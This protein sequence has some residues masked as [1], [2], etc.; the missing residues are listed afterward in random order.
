MSNTEFLSPPDAAKVVGVSP[1]KIRTFIER[2]ELAACNLAL[3]LGGRPRWRIRRSD[4]EDFLKRRAANA[5][6]KTSRR[7]R[8]QPVDV[9]EFF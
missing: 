8:R 6:V 1:D 7:I 5:V 2:N 9:I 3:N 4:L